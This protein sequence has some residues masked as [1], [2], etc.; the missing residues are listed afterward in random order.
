VVVEVINRK[1]SGPGYLW[2][3]DEKNIIKLLYDG[4]NQSIKSIQCCIEEKY[5]I[6]RTMYAIR[7]MAGMLGLVQ[8]KKVAWSENDI[9]KLDKM[10]GK[11]TAYK[12]ASKLNRSVS[13]VCHKANELGIKLRQRI[14]WYTLKDVRDILGVG[15]DTANNWLKSNKLI[16]SKNSDRN[17]PHW[18]IKESDLR[19]FIIKYPSELTGRNVDLV[20]IINLLCPDDFN[21][22]H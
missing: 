20:Q 5:G 2:I 3:E 9:N 12:I 15:E 17:T 13:S 10:A 11:Y 21:I 7:H 6:K 19:N 4:K 14:E 22:K 8:T 1:R 18:H 16:A